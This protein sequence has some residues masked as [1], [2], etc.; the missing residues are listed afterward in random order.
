MPLSKEGEETHRPRISGWFLLLHLLLYLGH[1]LMYFLKRRLLGWYDIEYERDIVCQCSELCMRG[2]SQRH[3]RCLHCGEVRHRQR[4][5]GVKNLKRESFEVISNS[6]SLAL[7][8]CA[9]PT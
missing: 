5:M 2:V 6:H 8:F 3:Q 9:L 7:V 4:D 1:L